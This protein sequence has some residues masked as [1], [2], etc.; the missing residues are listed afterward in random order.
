MNDKTYLDIMIDGV[1]LPTP[2]T[3][4]FEYSDLDVD[5]LRIITTGKLKR[6]RVRSDVQK[7][8]LGYLLTDIPDIDKMMKMIKPKEITVTLYD[9]STGSRVTKQMYAGNKSYSYIRVARGIK[10]Q[11]FKFNLTEV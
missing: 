5:S 1:K 11:G 9:N 3:L 8:K 4:D 10:G 7:I 6:N 2:S